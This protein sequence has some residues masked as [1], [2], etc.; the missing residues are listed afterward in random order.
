MQNKESISMLES[1]IN[2]LFLILSLCF[3]FSEDL[4][5]VK[6]FL[7]HEIFPPHK[8][9]VQRDLKTTVS[10]PHLIYMHELTLLC[11]HWGAQSYS[12]H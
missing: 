12:Y 8:Y 6:N 3:G 2:F 11:L 4:V 5:L 9:A 7:L 10:Y 1:D